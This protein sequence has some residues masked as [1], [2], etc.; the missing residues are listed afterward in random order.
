VERIR[1]DGCGWQLE[2]EIEAITFCRFF[3]VVG[4]A[5]GDT[6][7]IYVLPVVFRNNGN[8][9]TPKGGVRGMRTWRLWLVVGLTL[10]SA[11]LPF[12][13][14]E[15]NAPAA[16]TN[17][18]AIAPVLAPGVG[19]TEL[20]M[21]TNKAGVSVHQFAMHPAITNLDAATNQV[22]QL[23][24]RMSE[25]EDEAKAL[26]ARRQAM[27]PSLNSDQRFLSSFATNY[28]PKDDEGKKLK[29]RITA[30]EAELKTLHD[31][32]DRR[33]AEDPEFKAAKSK[34]DSNR[35]EWVNCE[36]RG[37]DLRRERV[38]VGGKIWQLQKLLDEAARAKAAEKAAAETAKP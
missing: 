8:L 20:G 19:F 23:R 17:A 11:T 18:P 28:V 16:D 26:A 2:I 30:A 6:E 24:K 32:L 31:E 29:A 5:I 37:E 4:N 38:E 15:T 27:R 13:L 7:P 21:A 3:L 22:V 25:L 34:V 36:K 1:G 9:Y 10:L 35:I 33:M 14:A 12:V